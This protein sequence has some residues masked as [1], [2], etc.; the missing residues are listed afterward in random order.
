MTSQQTKV[1]E[2]VASPSKLI[3][4]FD[5]LP[6]YYEKLAG[7]HALRAYVARKEVLDFLLQKIQEAVSEAQKQWC[8]KKPN[9]EVSTVYGFEAGVE[10]GRR[11]REEE[12]REWAKDNI[13]AGEE[14]RDYQLNNT[15]N[16]TNAEYYKGII[17]ITKAL[18]EFINKK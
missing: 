1:I 7:G 18:I 12:I 5:K 13:K 9:I 10:E 17:M 2:G 15:K 4:D 8:L 16:K 3:I 11:Q 6:H 14:N